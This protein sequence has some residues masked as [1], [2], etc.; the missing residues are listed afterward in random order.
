MLL[1]REEDAKTVCRLEQP[2]KYVNG[3]PICVEVDCP[4]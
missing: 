3:L 2:E 4:A 1:D